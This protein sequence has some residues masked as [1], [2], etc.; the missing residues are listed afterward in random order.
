MMLVHQE[1]SWSYF[2]LG[3]PKGVCIRSKLQKYVE[4]NSTYTNTH[5]NPS[6]KL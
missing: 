6:I 2:N 4:Y 5:L 1:G 3:Y